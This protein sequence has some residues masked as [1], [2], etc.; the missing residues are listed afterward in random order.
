MTAWGMHVMNAATSQL[1]DEDDC[2]GH[3][4]HG[5]RNLAAIQWGYCAGLSCHEIDKSLLLL[6]YPRDMAIS[7]KVAHVTWCPRDMVST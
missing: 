2:G 7:I 6:F 1:F 5:S 3:A 4:C